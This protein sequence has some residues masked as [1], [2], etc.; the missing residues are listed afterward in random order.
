MLTDSFSA[1]FYSFIDLGQRAIQTAE[2]LDQN[3]TDVMTVSSGNILTELRNMGNQ[4]ESQNQQLVEL[5]QNQQQYTEEVNHSNRS[6]GSLVSTLRN[7]AAAIGATALTREF[8][9]TSDEMSQITAKM[10][11]I[12]DGQQSTAELQNLVYQSAQ[13]TRTSYE[14]TANT[15]AR[16]GQNAKDAFNSN[17]EMIQFAEN[18]NKTFIIAGSSQEEIA[19]ASLQL[20]QALGSGVLR[21][22]ELNS[23][24]ESAPGLIQNIADYIENNNALLSQTA[25]ILDMNPDDLAG[26]VKKYIRDIASEGVLSADIV[27]GAILS[28]TDE[29]NSQFEEI[30]MTLSQAFTMGVNAIQKDLEESFANWNTFLN[31]DEGQ[32]TLGQLVSL[33][34]ILAQVG[35]GALSVVG[36]GALWVSQNLD[37]ILPILAAIGAALLVVHG[38]AILT[39]AANVAGGLATASAWALAHL[40]LILLAAAFASGLIAAQQ[41]GLGM[42]EVGGWV[43]QVL[44][45]LYAVGYNVFASLWNVIAAFAE[46][47]ANVWND[48]LGATARLFFDVFDTILGIVETVAGA[49]DSLL[50]SNLSSAV[51]GFRSQLS[52]WVDETFGENAIQIKRM[53]NLD[54]AATSQQW[55]TVGS[56]IG[57][58]LDNMNISL[59]DIA[60]GIGGLSDLAIPS[61]GDLDVGDVGTVGKVKSIDGD[62]N[63][64][65]ED[66]KMYRDLAERRYMT[67]LELQTLAPQIT[68]NIPKGAGDNISEQDLANRLKTILIQ[69][70]AAHTAIAHG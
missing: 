65:D 31:T 11:L 41:F 20:T 24:F 38:Q 60:G 37:F 59:S 50:G 68:I 25:K 28:A 30:P 66:I 58:K 4:L 5:I 51:S 46:F 18:L 26:N 56:N 10:N 63:L 40:P 13:R 3:L 9:Q 52:G 69:Q 7:A 61:A 64:S 49:I 23:V 67:N 27:K 44:G 47:F 17:A 57:S 48:P 2:R 39:A 8:L 53:A 32:R 62:V 1:S 22:E 21:G 33:F 12:N 36:Q 15:V 54:V 55:G 29:I 35:V 70:Q 43:G 34:T 16:L 42:E 14:A 45:M 6:A 19:S